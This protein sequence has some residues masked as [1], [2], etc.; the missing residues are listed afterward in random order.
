M[1]SLRRH[2]DKFDN[3][4]KEV[5]GINATISEKFAELYK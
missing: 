5:A 1:I 4:N 2:E 3:V